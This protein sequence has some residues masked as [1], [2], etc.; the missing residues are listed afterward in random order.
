MR[1]KTLSISLN[2]EITVESR[3]CQLD[4]KLKEIIIPNFRK[5][6]DIERIAVGKK[7]TVV[8]GLNGVGKSNLLSLVASGSGLNKLKFTGGNFQPAFTEYFKIES[9]ENFEEYKIYLE[10]E[11]QTDL[12]TFRKRLSFKDDTAQNRGIRVIPR[13]TNFGIEN[14]TNVN[15]EKNRVRK[16]YGS[17]G[18]ARVPLPTIF[19]SLS[20]L[21]PLGESLVTT[22]DISIR[23]QFFQNEAHTKYKEWYNTVLPGSINEDVTTA[24]HLSKEATESNSFYV[25]LESTTAQTQSVGQDNLGHIISALVDFYLLSLQENYNGGILCI[26]EV[27]ASLHPSAQI[28]LLDLLKI[29]ADELKLQIFLS[30]H[31]LTFLKEII[32][33]HISKPEDYGLV[34]FKDRRYPSPVSYINYRNLKADLFD[35]MN[36]SSPKVK[37]YCE[38]E[39]TRDVLDLLLRAAKNLN[40]TEY[41]QLPEFDIV[42]VFL[43]CNQLSALPEYDAHFRS[44]A[45]LLDGDARAESKVRIEDYIVNNEIAKGY[46]T[47]IHRDTIVYLPTFLAPE[48]YLYS[49]IHDYVTNARD[50][51]DFWRMLL[52]FPDTSN[53]TSDRINEVIVKQDILNNDELKKES[54]AQKIFDFARDSNILTDYYSSNQEDLITFISNFNK[55]LSIIQKKLKARGY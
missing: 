17:G 35:E 13:T 51:L 5:M 18:S 43:G 31:S 22:K 48:S 45:I 21:F 16:K 24:Q 8:S 7:I 44:V 1:L 26:D 42:P 25:P 4:I 19:L 55:A 32:S 37:L 23:N 15:D 6:K 30:T 41:H 49:I 20:R 14:R 34:Y 54:N 11:D 50:H 39:Q 47:R 46:Q 40:I 53:Y 10:Y 36:T 27:D 33:L 3:C 28:K 9:T 2:K 38:D 29:V 12:D 52:K